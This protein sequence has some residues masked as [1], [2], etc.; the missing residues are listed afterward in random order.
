MLEGMA[1]GLPVV[2]TDIPGIREAVGDAGCALLTPPG[3]A[4]AMAEA[5]LTVMEDRELAH[6]MGAMGRERI[7]AEFSVEK[8]VRE[9]V[10]WIE[11][12]LQRVGR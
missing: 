7:R 8:M 6:R 12:G 4:R 2:A 5:L 11:E 9:T 10:E 1:A 3:D